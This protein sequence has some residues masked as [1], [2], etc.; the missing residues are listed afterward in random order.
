MGQIGPGEIKGH[1][2]GQFFLNSKVHQ[3]EGNGKTRSVILFS[4]V[5]YNASVTYGH[6]KVK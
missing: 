6:Y 3:N 5:F 2:S 4:E 1:R